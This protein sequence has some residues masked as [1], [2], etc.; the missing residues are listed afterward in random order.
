MVEGGGEMLDRRVCI[1][2][3]VCVPLIGGGEATLT[4]PNERGVGGVNGGI[5]GW[6]ILPTSSLSFLNS[7][8][9]SLKGCYVMKSI[10]QPKPF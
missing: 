9:T 1:I 8:S 3:C 2:G 10:C 7:T 6:K 5:H 4:H